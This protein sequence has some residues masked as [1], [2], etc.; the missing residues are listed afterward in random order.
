MRI[1]HPPINKIGKPEAT[2][3]EKAEVVSSSL[4]SVLNGNLSYHISQ[5]PEPP[6]REWR[7]GVPA[8]RSEGGA[9]EH[10]RSPDE[11][12]PQDPLGAFQCPGGAG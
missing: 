1:P 10:P 9:P 5:A 6:D 4:D 11:H 7:N 12:G 8:I 2:I 3:M